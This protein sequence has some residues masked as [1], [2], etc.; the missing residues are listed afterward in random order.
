MRITHQLTLRSSKPRP[1]SR[2]LSFVEKLPTPSCWG[3]RYLWSTRTPERGYPLIV[4]FSIPV[5]VMNKFIQWMNPP[6]WTG[7]KEYIKGFWMLANFHKAQT[8]KRTPWTNLKILFGFLQTSPNRPNFSIN[9][10][11]Y[12]LTFHVTHSRPPRLKATMAKDW[13]ANDQHR[14]YVHLTWFAA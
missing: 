3:Q 5:F 6:L 8:S 4:S 14:F 1:R 2:R 13:L 7:L 12:C 9:M 10:A 11:F